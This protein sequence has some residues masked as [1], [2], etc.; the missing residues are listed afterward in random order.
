MYHKAGRGLLTLLF[1]ATAGP[2]V[3][4][5]GYLKPP[6]VVV[7]ILDAPSFPAVSLSPDR[8]RMLII[9]RASMPTI[10]DL[11]QPMLRLAGSRINPNTFGP[12]GGARTTGILIRDLA[13]GRE[14][15]V[16]VPNDAALSNISWSPNGRVLTFTHTNDRGIFLYAADPQTGAVRQVSDKRVNATGGGGFGGGSVC[17]W[18]ADNTRMLCRFVPDNIAAAA[19]VA[20]RVPHGPIIQESSGNTAP[21]RT[22]QDLLT[23]KHDE[24]LFDYYFTTQLAVVDVATGARTP[25]G[26][27]AIFTQ[28]S[29][30]PNGQYVLITRTRKPYSY[31]SPQGDFPR[32]TE[33][34]DMSGKAVHT[35]ANYPQDNDRPGWVTKLPR[36]A[37]WRSTAPATLLWVEALD[38]GNPRNKVEKRDKVLALAAPFSGTATEIART[39]ERFQNITW[40]EDGRALITDFE[41]TK[42]WRKTWLFNP[43]QPTQE[44]QLVW[45]MST[46]DAY[47]NPGSPEF[48]PGSTHPVVMVKN[49]NIYLTGNGASPQ[50][51][52]PFLDRFNLRTRKVERLWQTDA[53]HYESVTAML[54]DD[55]R[56]IITRRE[57]ITE[58]P[59]F[60]L[61]DV[62]SGK[63]TALTQFADPAPQLAGVTRQLVT[64]N[65]EDGVPLSAT[66]YLPPGYKQGTR[67]PV[68]MWAYPTEFAS[69]DAAGQVRGSP[70]RFTTVGGT[71]HL[72]FLTQGY[73]V[74]DNPSIPIIGGDTANNT[75]IHQL[76]SSAKAAVDKVVE[77]G[78]GDRNRIGVGGHSY[79][80]F[81]TAN[82]LAH[83]DLFRAGIARSG[84][85]NRTLTPFGFQNEER[86]FWEAPQIYSAM[87]PFNFA[88]KLK[89]PI[90]LIHGEADNNSGTFPIQSERMFAALKGHGGT[91]RYVVLPHESHGYSARESVMHTVAEMISWFD[92]YVKNAQPATTTPVSEQ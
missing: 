46:E 38:E 32:T 62:R 41:R 65:R 33:V 55:G 77:M 18:L 92:K 4:Q 84:A 78:V 90:L 51:D 20:P 25:V 64:Y 52:R 26:A 69:A 6:Q 50:G 22:Y 15:R 68:V 82:L 58:P 53:Q 80:A 21:A 3:A 40:L 12:H 66:L 5:D 11:A 27:P 91:V 56:R 71:S 74:F 86:T 37:F 7:D 28:S 57:S 59:N 23:D 9:E 88:H 35:V 70:N 47:K 48:R 54:D 31:Q 76:V 85:Y 61:R 17:S 81:M 43:D 60:Y 30:S 16:Q 67:L 63:A 72:F 39:P 19:P 87:S 13:K 44:W 73:A 42:R 45:D 2:L 34:W 8:T 29:V 79:G 24:D 36:Q 1:L 75:Y 49:D 83:S 89:E 10:A 14:T